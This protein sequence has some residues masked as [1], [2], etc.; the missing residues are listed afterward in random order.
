MCVQLLLE[1]QCFFIEFIVLMYVLFMFLD[2]GSCEYCNSK[3]ASSKL[4]NENILVVT[5]GSIDRRYIKI[6]VPI[7]E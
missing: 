4:A 3:R 1:S 7:T 6:N 2:D 5:I